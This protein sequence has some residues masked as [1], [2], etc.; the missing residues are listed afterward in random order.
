MAFTADLHI[1]SRYSMAVSKALDILHLSA[2]AKRKGIQVLG[3]GDF[4]HPAWREE[5][6]KNLRFDEET[7][8]FRLARSQPRLDFPERAA[9]PL[10]CLQTEISC[11]YKKNGKTRKIHNL[12]FAPDLK[13]ADKL[14]QKLAPFGNLNS[15][16]RP[17]LKLDSRDLLEMALESS[18][19]CVLIP[20]H[21][22]TPWHSLFGSKSGFDR[23]EDCYGDLTS[24][25]FALE[26]GLSSDPEMNRRW[27]ALDKYAMVSN[28]DAHSGQCLGREANLF[29]GNPSYDSMFQ[30]L[31]SA[32]KREEA[33]DNC[34]LEGTCEFYPEEGKY[35]LDGHRACGVVLKPEQSAEN[36]NICPVCGKPLTI[37]VLHRVMEL[38]D[39]KKAANLP[40]EPA[41]RMLVPLRE[42]ISQ[43][44]SAGASSKKV[45]ERYEKCVSELA[46][47][48]DL[49]CGAPENEIRD[50]WEELGE[51]VSR[52]R[53]GKLLINPGFDGQYGKVEIFSQEERKELA[54]KKIFPAAALSSNG[55]GRPQ[56]SEK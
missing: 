42:L 31:R 54:A 13:T 46:P 22:W 52:M 6:R 45:Q 47:E 2:W 38:S 32:A 55:E 11:V 43:I 51:A 21:I 56:G 34:R 33:P 48:M 15:N 7:G 1:H 35:H 50:Y 30:A 16:G 4:T 28:S 37:G 12:V 5:L 25:I 36:D 44:L 53:S 41:S 20:A 24:H 39:R 3:T 9:E 19:R 10:F 14:S 26:T 29:T 17:V 27:S 40:M 18:P 8:L 23:I 49:L